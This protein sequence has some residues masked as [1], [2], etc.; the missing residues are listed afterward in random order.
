MEVLHSQPAIS[1][2]SVT[3]PHVV[4]D[5]AAIQEPVIGS[6][7]GD[8]GPLYSSFTERSG[9]DIARLMSSSAAGTAAVY[10]VSDSSRTSSFAS[11][12]AE[13][14]DAQSLYNGAQAK[15]KNTKWK[16]GDVMVVLR[17]QEQNPKGWKQP[18]ESNVCDSL[19]DS[20]AYK[21]KVYADGAVMTGL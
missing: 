11:P 7:D 20:T 2:K 16:N 10:L 12:T 17:K 6:D 1:N 3:D 14:K 5:V 19:P 8:D 21:K 15:Y 4:Y 9:N 18:T 13:A